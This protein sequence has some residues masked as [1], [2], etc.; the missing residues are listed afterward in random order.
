MNKNLMLQGA[1]KLSKS[2]MKSVKG[3]IP[4]SEYCEKLAHALMY[5]DLDEGACQGAAYGAKKAG[6]GFS[7]SCVY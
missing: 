1:T 5:F 7:V 3:G 2:E 4:A 6:C